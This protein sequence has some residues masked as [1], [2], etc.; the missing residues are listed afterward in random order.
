MGWPGSSVKHAPRFWAAMPVVGLQDP[1]AE[2][3]EEALDQ[4]HRVAV[5]VGGDERDRVA[6]GSRMCR[7]CVTGLV[8]ERREV[9]VVE[10]RGRVDQHA[11][12][13][14]QVP[15]SV[16]V[17]DLDDPRDRSGGRSVEIGVDP[18]TFQQREELQQDEPLGGRRG[19][20]HVQIAEGCAERGEQ[21]GLVRAQVLDR[22]RRTSG[23]EPARVR[24]A[25]IAAVQ[26]RGPGI[27]ERAER[28]SQRGL[29]HGRPYRGGLAVR[30]EDRR[31]TGIVDERRVR[32]EQRSSEG[33]ADLDPILGQRHGGLE[34]RFPWKYGAG[35]VE[36][37]PA[38][39]R[40]RDRDRHGPSDRH[41]RCPAQRVGIGCPRRAA[42]RVDRERLAVGALDQGEQVAADPA[43][44][45]VGDRERHRR[46]QRRVHRGAAALEGGGAGPGR[47][48]VRGCD[49]PP[50]A[51][52]AERHG[53]SV[54]SPNGGGSI[55]CPA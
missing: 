48:R 54:S 45:R 21:A 20:A 6:V 32:I 24:A 4:G 16:H 40:A 5:C 50:G 52:C 41:S 22:D 37:V 3:P 42:A 14:G 15:I 31:E 44:V 43:H 2:A 13:V 9:P 12:G 17:G 7:R 39:D 30:I 25:D 1:R 53:R 8:S 35:S 29:A 27:G 55:G 11:V 38:R 28:S 51:V 18:E 36:F 10:Q 34:S 49:R 23:G 33:P 46:M 47:S 19:D 26:R